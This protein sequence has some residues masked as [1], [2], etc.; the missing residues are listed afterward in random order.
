MDQA[1]NFIESLEK[2]RDMLEKRKEEVAL[3]RQ[4]ASP[5]SAPPHIALAQGMDAMSSDIV[6]HVW[7]A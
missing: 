2:T 4:A 5:S 7:H 6:P 3:A 1:I